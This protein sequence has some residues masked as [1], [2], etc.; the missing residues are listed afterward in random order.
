VSS[1]TTNWSPVPAALSCSVAHE[2]SV[3]ATAAALM[4]GIRLPLA[5]AGSDGPRLR[6]TGAR[7]PASTWEPPPRRPV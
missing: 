1:S 2:R 7:T 3:T 5:G 6:G 4:D